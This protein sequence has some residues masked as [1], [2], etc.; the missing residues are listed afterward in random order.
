MPRDGIRSTYSQCPFQIRMHDE[1][2]LIS[3][4]TAF[5]YEHAGTWFL[6]TNWHNLSG[7][8]FLTKESLSQSKRFPTYIEAH[9]SSY[10]AGSISLPP[11]SFTTVSRRVEI[12]K[13]YDPLWYEHPE[14]GSS[15]DVIVLP[16]ERPAHCP[17]E[18]HNAANLIGKHKIPVRPGNIAFVIGFPKSISVGFGLPLWK[19]GYIASEPF[20]NVKIGGTIAP[21]GGL[22]GGTELPAFFVDTQTRE[23]MSG[24]PVFAS[25]VG[26]WDLSDPYRPIN[27]DSREFW[28]RHDIALV[29]NFME[30]VG[31]YSGRVGK[32][33]EGAA[34]GLCWREEVLEK[35]CA[36]KKIAKHPHVS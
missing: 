27:P 2:G 35:I 31:C 3:T 34:L 11:G 32:E 6:V 24:A 21:V 13:N 20:Y 28:E 12:Y 36:S 23:G 1:H 25:Y 9:M 26:T 18:M 10:D 4:G 29:G 30:F 19:A 15:C 8:H 7:K 5:F 22:S 14:L 16:F 33:E 17:K